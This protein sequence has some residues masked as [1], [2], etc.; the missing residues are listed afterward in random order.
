MSP[1]LVLYFPF[2]KGGLGIVLYFA[3]VTQENVKTFENRRPLTE[4][5][6]SSL[7]DIAEGM[8]DSVPCTGCRYCT[9]KCPQELAIPELI[10]RYNKSIF[11]GKLDMEGAGEH[12]VPADCVGCQS[13]ETVCPQNIKIAD[14]MADMT[15]KL[16]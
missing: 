10:K 7:L 8:K 11:S 5:E 2:G 1:L 12:E 13:C 6:L 15:E 14:M 3:A 9:S 16:K 4:K